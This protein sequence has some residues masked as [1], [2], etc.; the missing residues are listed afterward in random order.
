M[1]NQDSVA[2]IR[3]AGSLAMALVLVYYR[4]DLNKS[5]ERRSADFRRHGFAR[6]RFVWG[7]WELKDDDCIVLHFRVERALVWWLTIDGESA[8]IS[9]PTV[10]PKN[11]LPGE[12]GRIEMRFVG[13]LE[14]NEDEPLEFGIRYC[15]TMGTIDTQRFQWMIW[16]DPAPVASETFVKLP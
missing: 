7:D 9:E 11:F 1:N 8:G 12:Y 6:P 4:R 10:M 16:R 14:A 3:I 5:R 13:L 15:T 2:W